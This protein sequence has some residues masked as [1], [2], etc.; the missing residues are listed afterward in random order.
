M[1]NTKEFRNISPKQ[2]KGLY[3]TAHVSFGI[4]VPK[5]IRVEQFSPDQWEEFTEEWA[6]SLKSIYYKVERFAGSGDMGLDVVGFISDNTFKGGWDNYQCKHYDQPLTPS[7]IWIE[8]GKIIYYAFKGEFSPPRTYYFVA[9][10]G[11]GT[12]LGKWLAC[13]ETLKIVCKNNW[14]KYCETNILTNVIVKLE[15]DLLNYFEHFDFSIFS[16]KSLVELIEGHAR[17]SFHTVRFGGGLPSRLK[18]SK[19]P[20]KIAGEESRY[21][22]QLYEAYSDHVGEKIN[23]VNLLEKKPKLKEDFLRQRERFYHAESLR[24]F[25]RD[26]VPTG[27]FEDLQDDIYQGVIDICESKH[28]DGLARMRATILQSAQLSITSNPLSA[29]TLIKDRQGICHQLANEDRLV[30]VSDNVDEKEN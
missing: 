26:T 14:G 7:D 4:P 27:T 2:Q 24:N 28:D 11:I 20:D 8:I 30:W 17:T 16:S 23:N 5:T 1:I 6:S 18:P 9:S 3:T 21:I 12:K 15:N 13:P 29:V 19:P 10:K 22:E 25:A